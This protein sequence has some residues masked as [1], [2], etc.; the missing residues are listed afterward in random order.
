MKYVLRVFVVLVLAAG[1]VYGV[2]RYTN[3]EAFVNN[4]AEVLTTVSKPAATEKNSNRV[5]LASIEKE[6]LYLYKGSKGVLL[7]HG[8]NEVTFTNWS[9]FIDAE[10][11]EMHW[12]DFNGDGSKELLIKAVSEKKENGDFLYELYLLLPKTDSD[13]K[14]AYDVVYA[15][16]NTWSSILDNNI[17]E[18]M[19]QLKNCKKI[20]QFSMNSK[21]KGISYNKQTGI[22]T[23]GYSGYARALQNDKGEY[24]TV[25]NWAKGD[26]IYSVSKDNIISINIDINVGYKN[27]DKTQ[28]AGTIYF[29][30]FLNEDNNF[31]VTEKSMVF[32]PAEEYRVSD[33]ND[34]AK[35][36]WKYIENNSNT[37]ATEEN[38]QI[39]WI[40]YS[41][42]Y[43]PD[44]FTQ[45]K[46]F[47]SDL[48]DINKVEKIKLTEKYI[49]LTAKQGVSFDSGA[50]SKGEF[51][52]VTGDKLD[53]AYT[54][55]IDTSGK[56]EVLRITFDK[57]YPQS[58][59]KKFTINYG[60]K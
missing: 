36:S 39:Q 30:L 58:E 27:S 33:P 48:S 10:E 18:E 40:K 54:A 22:A 34:T 25:D 15:S 52:V 50:K 1:I 8:K 20:I 53:I 13:G 3:P 4:N 38:E 12:A 26:G 49:E 56:K 19:R 35:E 37:S 32:K 9:K 16:R 57:A 2:F 45:T 43:S 47:T 59:I 21:S 46:D 7:K 28:N 44:V 24:M 23:S 55:E 5:L 42:E 29:E 17:K 11:P 60:T 14:E 41:T 31:Q 51:S 6:D